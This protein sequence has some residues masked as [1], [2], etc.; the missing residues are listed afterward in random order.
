MPKTDQLPEV[1]NLPMNREEFHL[2]ILVLDQFAATA[3][4]QFG[5][6]LKTAVMLQAYVDEYF[7][8]PTL[9]KFLTRVAD[10]HEAVC[11]NHEDHD[12]LG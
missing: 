11:P 7:D 9:N 10:L 5:S 4:G 8:A 3:N 1:I 6:A 2:L 12:D